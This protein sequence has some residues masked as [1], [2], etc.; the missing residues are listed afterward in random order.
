MQDKIKVEVLKLNDGQ[1]NV[2]LSCKRLKQ[3]EN[4]KE[5]EEDVKNNKIFHEKVF[6]QNDKG[7]VVN[8]KG[9]R[10]FIPHSLSAGQKEEVKP[11][12]IRQMPRG[13]LRARRDD[14]DHHEQKSIRAEA[15]HQ[16]GI[17]L[18]FLRVFIDVTDEIRKT[19]SGVKQ[20]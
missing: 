1:G 12:V 8:Y 9:I 19:H 13:I 18:Q 11:R 16:N 4:K 7:L 14:R 20:K 5:F 15:G 2:L 6:E 17:S 3:Q 10:I